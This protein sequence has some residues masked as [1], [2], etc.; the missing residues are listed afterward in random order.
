MRRLQLLTLLC[1]EAACAVKPLRGVCHARIEAGYGVAS[2]ATKQPG[3]TQLDIQVGWRMLRLS[4][5]LHSQE[6]KAA[7][8]SQAELPIFACIFADRSAHVDVML[9]K[10]QLHRSCGQDFQMVRPRPSCHPRLCLA[11]PTVEPFLT[12]SHTETATPQYNVAAMVST[13]NSN[14][15]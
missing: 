15:G 6:P 4:T 2:Q 3:P 11:R 7:P 8:T 9:Q 14:S 13:L 1:C 5:T 12:N 10:R